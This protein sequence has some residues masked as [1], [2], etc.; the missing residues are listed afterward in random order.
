[1]EKWI[2]KKKRLKSDSAEHHQRPAPVIDR[3]SVLRLEKALEAK[4]TGTIDLAL[5]DLLMM[6]FENEQKKILSDIWDQVLAA[7]FQNAAA[8]TGKLV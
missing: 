1:M 4:K 7:D 6:P 8:L 2:P 5:N 3:A